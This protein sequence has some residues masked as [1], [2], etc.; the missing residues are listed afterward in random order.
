[1]A[2]GLFGRMRE[3]VH[4]DVVGGFPA[5]G[6]NDTNGYPRSSKVG[7]PNSR[8]HTGRDEFS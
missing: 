2:S 3:A 6:K 1:M 5:E 7:G 8:E 4:P